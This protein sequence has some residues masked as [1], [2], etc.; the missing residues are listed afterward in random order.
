MASWRNSK[1]LFQ[2]DFQLL[3][4]IPETIFP[5]LKIN[6]TFAIPKMRELFECPMV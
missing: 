1:E 5:F 4:N 3:K 2:N 6:F